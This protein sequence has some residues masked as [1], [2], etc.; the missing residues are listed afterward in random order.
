MNDL[1]QGIRAA[2]FSVLGDIH[3]VGEFFGRLAGRTKAAMFL[4]IKEKC[5][6]LSDD[7]VIEIMVGARKPTP[8]SRD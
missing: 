3:Q 5:P 2:D 6:K 4:E 1:L 8:G 7:Q